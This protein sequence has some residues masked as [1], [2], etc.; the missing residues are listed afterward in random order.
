MADNMEGEFSREF[1]QQMRENRFSDWESLEEWLKS[2]NI[3][4]SKPDFKIVVGEIHI[5]SNMKVSFGSSR[6]YQYNLEKIKD[7]IIKELI[8]K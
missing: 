7:R 3:P 1:K 2:Q 4:Y 6:R 5:H 8:I